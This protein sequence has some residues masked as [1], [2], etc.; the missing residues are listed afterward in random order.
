MKWFKNELGLT[1]FDEVLFYF[2]VR[3]LLI[4]LKE[5][6]LRQRTY[7]KLFKRLLREYENDL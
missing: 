1:R 5:K 7:G 6:G 3:M 4:Y 2:I